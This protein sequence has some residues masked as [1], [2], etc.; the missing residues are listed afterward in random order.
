MK[1]NKETEVWFEKFYPEVKY[2][3][4]L[5]RALRPGIPLHGAGQ[6]RTGDDKY[7]YSS[8]NQA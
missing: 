1:S 2:V 4:R 8:V 5:L 6:W 3:N 7:V